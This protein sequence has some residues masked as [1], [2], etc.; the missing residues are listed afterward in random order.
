MH[1]ADF[2][3]VEEYR[4]QSRTTTLRKLGD[5]VLREAASPLAQTSTLSATMATKGITW[6]MITFYAPFQG[7]FYES[8]IK[9]L[10]HSLYKTIGKTVFPLEQLTTLL[11]KM[12][13]TLNARPLT[14]QEEH[15]DNRPILRP[16]D[17]IQRDLIITHPIDGLESTDDPTF[18]P[19]EDTLQLRT[20]QQAEEALRSSY[21]LTEQLWK[22]WREQYL[23][24]P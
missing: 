4:K 22:T 10:K 21:H 23:T 13:G 18:H 2:S 5:R 8:L 24:P 19:S 17:F 14:Y 6:Q 11:A 20:R 16:I 3:L 9:T 12:E 15:W 7:A 1:F